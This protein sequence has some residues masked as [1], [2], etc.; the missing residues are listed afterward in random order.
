MTLQKRGSQW[1]GDS[2]ADVH[3]EITRYAALNGYRADHV[4]DAVC[5]CGGRNFLLSLDE[6]AGVAVRR[7][8]ACK[9]AHPIGDSS[10]FMN[11]ARLAE[12]ACP[13]GEEALEISVGVSLYNGSQDVRWLYLG[14]RC[15][16]CGLTAVYGDWK[17]EHDDYRSL[18]AKV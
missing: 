2:Q 9:A 17:N 5:M 18:L 1:Y 10:Q 11:E 16:S 15:G 12:C 14:C 4:A 3:G 7:C 6:D 13:C 8:A